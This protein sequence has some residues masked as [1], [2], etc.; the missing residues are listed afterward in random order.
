[1]GYFKDENATRNTIDA[2]RF[3]HSG[4]VGKL[5]KKGNLWITGRIK[6]LIITAGGENIAP[7]LIEEEIKKS[8]P[9]VS[10]AMVIGDARKF[11]T[12]ILTFR[13][14]LDKDGKY[15]IIKYQLEYQMNCHLMF[16][17]SLN[18]WDL[19]LK[20]LNKQLRILK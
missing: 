2:D 9:I 11:L 20:I 10:N 17:K 1:M 18:H 19:K 15:L 5:D 13:Y 8:I 7:I 6:E 14:V 16:Y 3:L 4:D 12:T